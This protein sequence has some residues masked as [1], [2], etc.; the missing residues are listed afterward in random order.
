MVYLKGAGKRP[1]AQF[2]ALGNEFHFPVT[3]VGVTEMFASRKDTKITLRQQNV[4]F[5]CVSLTRP[6]LYHKIAFH[7]GNRKDGRIISF[8]HVWC[9]STVLPKQHMS[10]AYGVGSLGELGSGLCEQ[11]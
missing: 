3:S 6:F 8:K 11:C 4:D 10:I 5:V 1:R 7:I 2:C 9:L